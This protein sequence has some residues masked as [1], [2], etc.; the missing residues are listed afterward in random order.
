MSGTPVWIAAEGVWFQEVDKESAYE[1]LSGYHVPLTDRCVINVYNTAEEIKTDGG[2][3]D[4]TADT[5]PTWP[6]YGIDIVDVGVQNRLAFST[7][8]LKWCSV[9]VAT[10]EHPRMERLLN[11][12]SNPLYDFLEELRWNPNTALAP[13]IKEAAERFKQATNQNEKSP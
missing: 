8:G 9:L 3:S 11:G 6:R 2:M 13:A 7:V 5:I 1:K 12:K 4:E 10:H